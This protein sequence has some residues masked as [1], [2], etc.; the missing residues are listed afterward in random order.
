MTGSWQNSFQ[1]FAQ[2]IIHLS[3][4]QEQATKTQHINCI[5]F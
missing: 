3:L 1:P 4:Y 2:I 5:Q